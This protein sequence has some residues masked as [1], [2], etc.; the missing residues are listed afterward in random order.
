MAS[1]SAWILDLDYSS[2]SDNHA[3]QF[4]AMKLLSTSD[5]DLVADDADTPIGI[6]QNKPTAGQAASIRILG[7]SK[8]VVDGS[9]T[10]IAFGDPIGINDA[11]IG[12]KTT[13]ADSPLVGY[14]QGASSAANDVIAVLL[15]GPGSVYRTPAS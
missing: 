13:V 10:A 6:L 1:E 4:K 12:I 2:H 15:A 7:V 14:A 3:N 9:G 11:A 8:M 5:C